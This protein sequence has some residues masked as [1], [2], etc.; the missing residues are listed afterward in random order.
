MLQDSSPSA[1]S[2][3]SSSSLSSSSWYP[4][5]RANAFLAARRDGQTA[6]WLRPT[7]PRRDDRGRRI[8][9]C[10][11]V[12]SR[13]APAAD[14]SCR[15]GCRMGSWAGRC[16]RGRTPP[17]LRSTPNQRERSR[18]QDGCLGS[19]CWLLAA[20]CWLLAAVR[21]T[22]SRARV[23]DCWRIVAG[24]SRHFRFNKCWELGQVAPR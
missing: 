7:P 14:V 10:L 5:C 17:G 13:P 16:A 23:G 18:L 3:S 19:G 9:A 2:S 8:C 4:A 22:P 20:S 15:W 6:Q 1:S 21:P 12:R 11:D 24:R